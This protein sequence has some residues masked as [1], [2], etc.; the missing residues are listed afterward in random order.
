M[1]NNINSMQH[2]CACGAHHATGCVCMCMRRRSRMRI[3][4]R[5]VRHGQVTGALGVSCHVRRSCQCKTCRMLRVTALHLTRAKATN[6]TTIRAPLTHMACK[7]HATR[8]TQRTQPRE[9]TQNVG[10]AAQLHTSG[11]PL[12][13]RRCARRRRTLLQGKSK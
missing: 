5:R 9:D 13:E 8:H 1:C 7:F 11:Q 4:A 2:R 6:W 12:S 3:S 10:L